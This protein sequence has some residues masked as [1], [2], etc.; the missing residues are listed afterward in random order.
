VSAHPRVPSRDGLSGPRRTPLS[1]NESVLDE[2]EATFKASRR[3]QGAR[4]IDDVF[5]GRVVEEAGRKRRLTRT[6]GPR[7]DR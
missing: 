6:S 5:L 4:K 2:S 7:K 3:G 1:H